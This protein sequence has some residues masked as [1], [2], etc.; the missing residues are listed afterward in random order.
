MEEPLVGSHGS[1]GAGDPGPAQTRSGC[2]CEC[3]GRC[4]VSPASTGATT[5]AHER[6]PHPQLAL[7]LA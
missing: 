4:G 3:P 7:L 5:G 1:G 2:I 6:H